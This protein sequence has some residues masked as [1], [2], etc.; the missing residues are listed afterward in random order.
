MMME[1]SPS[2]GCLFQPDPREPHP[3]PD[4][5]SVLGKVRRILEVFGLDDETLS[6]SELARRTGL[7]KASV[8]RLSQELV[9][10]GL[11]E[12]RNG[13]YRLGMRLFE[14]GQRVPRQRILRD[15]ARPLMIDLVQATN[16]TSHLAVSDGLEVLYLDKVSGEQTQ[17]SRPSR[18]AGRMPLHC[19]ATGKALLAFGPRQLLEEVM[20]APLTRVTPRTTVA[21]GLLGQELRKAREQGYVAEFEQTRIGYMS[22]AI[23]LTGATGAV[24]AALSVT[25]PTTRAKVDRFAGLLNLVGRRMTKL[26]S[27][28]EF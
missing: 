13:E 27:A 25:A 14:I 8:H 6:L 21:P 16:E 18:V 10:W 1:T 12:R 15:L 19:T 17:I 11:L 23:P 3:A 9:Q 7:A 22:V 5:N 20:S 2:P 24:V 28:Q 26:L 4:S